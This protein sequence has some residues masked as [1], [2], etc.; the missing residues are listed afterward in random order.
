MKELRQEIKIIWKYLKQYKKRVFFASV[1]AMV[2]I[3]ISAIVPYLYGRLVDLVSQPQV[4]WLL[5]N[6]LAIWLL[7]NAVST[8]SR[9]IS[10]LSGSILGVDVFNDFLL[11]AADHLINL[12]LSFHKEK[13]TGEIFSK[14]DRAAD[15]L[16]RIIDDILIWFFPQFIS[17]FA[18]VLILFLVQWQLA[19][20]VSFLFLGYILITIKKTRPIIKNQEELSKTFEKVFGNL[21]DS[22]FNVQT[23]KSCAA[24]KFQA[25]KTAKDFGEGLSPVFKKFM[26]L[27][28]SL[29]F[30]QSFFFS[31]GFV[32]VFGFS[33]F[34]LRA[35]L[36]TAGKLVMFLGYLNL[37]HSPLSALAWHWQQ[38]RTGMAAIKRAERF[39]EIP[40]EDFNERGEVLKDIKGKVE[41][42]NVNFGYRDGQLILENINFTVLPGQ[43]IAL[44]GG[45]GEGK[46]TLVDLISFYFKPSAGRILI[47]DINIKNL[48][49]HFL[50]KTIAYVP[51]E[52][53]LFNDTIKNNIL[54][55][56]P[57]A[58]D[59]EVVKVAKIANAHQ[60]IESFPKKY[61]T[62]VGERGIKLST[63]QKQRIAIARALIRDPKILILDEATSSLD[64]ESERLVQIALE[65]LIENRTTF[66]IAHRLST[67]KSVDKIFILKEKKIIEKGTHQELMKKKGAYFKLYSL[68]FSLN[69]KLKPKKTKRSKKKQN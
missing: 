43:K 60:F 5:L 28:H 29:S 63:G 25:K 30:W 69:P 66:I 21:Y 34:L 51:Q 22:F 50:R 58:I 42:K 65:K 38:F 14:I 23:I 33:I 35:N 54:Y 56:K 13:K 62:L 47:D 20:G 8:I 7:M 1:L 40:G 46:T 57:E 31:I 39:L 67:V 36:I 27:W 49:L 17:A 26:V 32:L 53:T 59:D 52:I 10:G 48:N 37:I 3:L 15:A 61:D 64:S 11:K 45:S 18:G 2:S 12:P 16:M 24:E 6:L 9:R 55:G 19:L 41:F 4:F 44:V 68:Q